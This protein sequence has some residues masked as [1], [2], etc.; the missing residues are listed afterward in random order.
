L[1]TIFDSA[2]AIAARGD[3]GYRADVHPGWTHGGKANGGYLLAMIGRAAVETVAAAGGDHPHPLAVNATYISA[4]DVGAVELDAEVLRVGRSASQARVRLSQA[5]RTCVESV[6]T[7]GRLPADGDPHWEDAPPVEVQPFEECEGGIR[8][9]PS[10]EGDMEGAIE[11]RLDPATAGFFG[12]EP[13]GRGEFRG[14]LAFKGR[15]ADPI[16][17]LFV[18]DGFPPATLDLGST[19]WVPTL[20]LTVYNRALPAPGPL[21]IRQRT[22]LVRHGLFDEVCEVWDSGGRLVTQATQLAGVRF[23]E[24]AGERAKA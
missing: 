19:G 9:T 6:L 10:V 3:G 4:P 5:G 16:A 11:R 8:T 18:A 17:L 1:T 21:R 23:P 7:L 13:T 14:W 2:T 20:E 15:D 22:R 24:R 12:G